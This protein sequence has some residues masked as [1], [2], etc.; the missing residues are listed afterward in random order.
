MYYIFEEIIFSTK[1]R[2]MGNLIPD[3]LYSMDLRISVVMTRQEASGLIVTSP[4]IKPTSYITC[5]G[6]C[7]SRC[8]PTSYQHQ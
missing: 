4:V 6:K 5:G 7:G 2:V 8:G 1:I 3:P